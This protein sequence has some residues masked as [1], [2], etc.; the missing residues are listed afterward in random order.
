MELLFS[1]LPPGQGLVHRQAK[2]ARRRGAVPV[3]GAGRVFAG[4][5]R[6]GPGDPCGRVGH[7]GSRIQGAPT[8]GR[9]AGRPE[10]PAESISPRAV[11]G[12]CPSE[13]GP[14]QP[15]LQCPFSGGGRAEGPGSPEPGTWKPGGAA[16][17]GGGA[18]PTVAP[19]KASCCGRRE[20]EDCR[21]GKRTTE[22]GPA[23]RKDDTGGRVGGRLR[24][25]T[26]SR[27]TQ[28][29]STP[30]ERGRACPAGARPLTLAWE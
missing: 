27:G 20:L 22:L 6:C 10:K 29:H 30:G 23:G 18:R 15:H 26:D 12:R 21:P 8:P 7:L 24:S 1:R 3:A 2:R 13:G 17:V 19:G 5:G 11:R 4:P 16:Q 14:N 28:R 9:V 25:F